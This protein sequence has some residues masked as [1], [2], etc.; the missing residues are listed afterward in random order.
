[1][2]FPLAAICQLAKS[3]G[4][5]VLPLEQSE[6]LWIPKAKTAQRSS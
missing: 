1:M 5:R 3:Q 4:L 6:A 2:L